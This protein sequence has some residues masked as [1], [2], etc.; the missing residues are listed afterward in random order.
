M[1]EIMTDPIGVQAFVE[2]KFRPTNNFEIMD[3]FL[4]IFNFM[5]QLVMWRW[6][7]N[8]YCLSF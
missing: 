8:K 3:F 6:L 1:Y 2:R 5:V 4:F 7:F